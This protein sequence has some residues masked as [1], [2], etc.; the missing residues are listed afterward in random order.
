VRRTG[1]PDDIARSVV[2]LLS[3]DSGCITGQTPFV[4]GGTSV[5]GTGGE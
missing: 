1:T 2:F 5:S 3:P 4:C